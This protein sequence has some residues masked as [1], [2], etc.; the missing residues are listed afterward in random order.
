MEGMNYQGTPKLT[1][2]FLDIV[3]LHVG[4]IKGYIFARKYLGIGIFVRVNDG[5]WESE[6]RALDKR[7][8]VPDGIDYV[9]D[10]STETMI[11]HQQER[12]LLVG[13]Y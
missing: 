13:H 12:W 5:G 2:K 9:S 6:A 3:T 1:W 11:I 7:I 10:I 4:Q 8:G